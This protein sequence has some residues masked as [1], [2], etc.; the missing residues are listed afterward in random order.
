MGAFAAFSMMGLWPVAGQSVYLVS[1]PFFEAVGVT[2]PATNRTATIRSATFDPTYER[3][4][5]QSA[6]L[7]GE[8]YSKSWV[9]HEFFTEGWTLE[10]TLGEEESD[11]GT[12]AGD[13]PPSMSDANVF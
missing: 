5:V 12:A 11:W 13:L 10:L 8:P 9:P 4:Y 6:V 3:I 7:N 1:A 2:S